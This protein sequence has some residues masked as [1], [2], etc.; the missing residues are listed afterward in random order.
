MKL[1]SKPFL[2]NIYEKHA[3]TRKKKNYKNLDGMGNLDG[4]SFFIPHFTIYHI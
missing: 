2:Q 1:S 3:K 4:T